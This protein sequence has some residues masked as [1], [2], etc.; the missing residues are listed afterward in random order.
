MIMK[1]KW[2]LAITA[3]LITVVAATV[4]TGSFLEKKN[5]AGLQVITPD[6]PS[7][8]F[9]NG[10]YLDKTPL[11][12]KS[13]KPGTYFLRIQPDDSTLVGH[14]TTITLRPGVL[15]VATW[16]SA[17][18]PEMSG[19]VI[20]EME[21]LPS[22]KESEVSVISIP[23]NA[24]ISLDNG[25]KEFAPLRIANVAAGPHEFEATL[26]SY[27]TQRHTIDIVKGYR[28]LLTVK[29]A[30]LADTNTEEKAVSNSEA[31]SSATLL[32]PS[33]A[34]ISGK[35]ATQSARFNVA[36]D[37]ATAQQV[38]ILK[39]NFFQEGKEVLRV[40]NN[41]GTLGTEVGFVDVGKRYRFLESTT[42][43]WIKLAFDSKEGW[44]S[45]E[46]TRLEPTD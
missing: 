43:G 4:L 41:P 18:R 5:R 17:K 8:V 46:F 22:S 21:P 40:R 11:I 38:L 45:G 16:K 7:T 1:P 20:I 31:T 3:L 27:E 37:S 26:P 32:A 13:L 28:L 19:G 10:Q 44:V 14:D 15:S 25:V 36:T 42:S 34:T 39:T 30:K 24:I 12:E 35:T 9:L 33:S 29:L 6:V 2:I 23:D